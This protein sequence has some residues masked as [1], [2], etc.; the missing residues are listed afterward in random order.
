MT[1]LCRMG[2]KENWAA[3]SSKRVLGRLGVTQQ[4]SDGSIKNDL[5]DITE[6]TFLPFSSV[7]HESGYN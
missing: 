3:S 4:R 7:A 5:V 6:V 2:R 1:E